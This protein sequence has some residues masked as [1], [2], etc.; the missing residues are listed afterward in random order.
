MVN[1]VDQSHWVAMNV[2]PGPAFRRGPRDPPRARDAS[3]QNFVKTGS[4]SP[5]IHIYIYRDIDIDI[6]CIYIYIYIYII[7]SSKQHVTD[8]PDKQC[9]QNAIKF[10]MPT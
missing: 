1:R 8:L 2:S 7:L 10:Q 6:P 9:N 3:D 5:T 4:N